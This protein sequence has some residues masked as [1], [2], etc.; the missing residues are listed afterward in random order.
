MGAN[1]TQAVAIASFLCGFTAMC[2]APLWGGIF[3]V[4]IGA[5]LVGFSAVMFR[6]C[7]PWEHAKNGG[8]A[9]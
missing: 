6:K 7:K 8:Q 1:S 5:A 4:V 2:A 3:M 9:R